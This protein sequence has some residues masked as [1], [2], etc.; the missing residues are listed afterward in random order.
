MDTSRDYAT[1]FD[2]SSI[3]PIIGDVLMSGGRL[4]GGIVRAQ[5]A[6][7]AEWRLHAKA[8]QARMIKLEI[9]ATATEVHLREET[10]QA[11]A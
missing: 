3:R 6:F 9:A 8:L 5:V 2:E 10:A 7:G 11:L 4:L 1:W